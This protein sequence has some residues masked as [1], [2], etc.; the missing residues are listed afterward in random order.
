MARK[1][2]SPAKANG[3]AGLRLDQLDRKVTDTRELVNALVVGLARF[4]E[5][6]DG[7]MVEQQKINLE[8]QKTTAEQQKTNAELQKTNA[9]MQKANVEMRAQ[10][11]AME[12]RADLSEKRTDAI[13]R[14]LR[15]HRSRIQKVE[16]GARN[17]K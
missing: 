14:E 8:Q 9:E 1:S 10:T 15:Q 11:K 2:S 4:A 12:R 3:E 13:I 16:Q 17:R 7:F 5:R 6:A